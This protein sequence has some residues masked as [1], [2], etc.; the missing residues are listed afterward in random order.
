M[1]I[2]FKINTIIYP[3]TNLNSIKEELSL[4]K[5]WKY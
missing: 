4:V 3:S 1:L 2:V 5:Y